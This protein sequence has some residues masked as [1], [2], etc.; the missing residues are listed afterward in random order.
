MK[1]ALALAAAALAVAAVLIAGHPNPDARMIANWPLAGDTRDRS[2]N[3]HDAVNHGA[4]LQAIGRDGRAGG[5]AGFNGRG[6]FLE[7]ATRRSLDLGTGDFTL[8]AWVF[9]DRELDDV[10]GDIA[11]QYDAARRRGFRLSIKNNAGVTFNQANYRQLQFGI[12]DNRASDWIDCGRPGKNSILA[13]ALAVHDGGLYAGTCE[14]DAGESGRVYRYAGD[15][16]WVDCGSPAPSNAITSM[17][18]YDG[19]L[20]VGTGKYRLGGS[21]LTES[22]NTHLGG[23]VFRYDGGTRWTDCGQLPAAEA[24]SGL[25]VYRGRLYAGSLY[26]PA[27]FFRYEGGTKWVD[28]GTPGGNRVEALGVYDGF[29]YATCY[30]GGRVYRFDGAAWT[31]CGQLGDPQI[32]TQTYSLAVHAGRL[33]V[34]TWR[35]GRVYRMDETADS[36]GRATFAWTDVGRLG[37]ELEVMGMLVHNG[38]LIAGTLPLAEVYEFDG[39]AAWRRLARLDLTP[40]VKYRRAWTMAEFQG[41]LFTSVLPSGRVFAHEVGKN[42]TSDREL[43]AGWRHVAAVKSAGRLELFVDGRSVARS[44]SFN[45]DEFNLTSDQPIR[46]GLGANDYFRGRLSDMRI[47]R[48]ALDAAD[49]ARLAAP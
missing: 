4:D 36:D 32:N 20:Y 31:D 38:R 46:L 7:I 45:P 42:V 41:K 19:K 25:V 17:A 21:A 49:I 29:L 28:C 34:G 18:A 40:D 33:Y 43:T 14:P 24:V 9:T 35:S 11:S 6:A 27:G 39:Q 37:E 47:Y 23:R 26:K 3:G 16:E 15:A 5:A 13:F 2:G 44:E 30:D 8:T 48:G 22:E 1:Y 10:P 12:D